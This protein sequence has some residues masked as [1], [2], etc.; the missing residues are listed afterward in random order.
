MQ[1]ILFVNKDTYSKANVKKL[2]E[3]TIL[4]IT[5]KQ[6]NVSGFCLVTDSGDIYGKYY[7][8]TTLYRKVEEGYILSND[9]SVYIEPKPEIPVEDQ[10]YEPTIDEVKNKKKMELEN[11]YLR[12]YS[13]GT[14]T[15]LSNK[16]VIHIPNIDNDMLIAIGTAYNS[17]VVLLESGSTDTKI[18]FDISQVCNSYIPLDIMRI[19]IAIQSLVIYNRSLKNELLSTLDRCD[20]IES[21]NELIYDESYLD[22]IGLSSFKKSISDGQNVINEI[23]SKYIPTGE[24]A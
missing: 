10:P 13:L 6:P 7:D 19:Y 15:T 24:N 18:P 17:A 22:E 4:I 2:S 21:V 23:L 1:N 5:D 14:D 9:D 11:C 8:Y 20:S 12:I 16:S 3:H